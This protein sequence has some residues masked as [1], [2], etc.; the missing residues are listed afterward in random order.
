[1]VFQLSKMENITWHDRSCQQD[2]YFSE[3]LNKSL[4][5]SPDTGWR[6]PQS[7]HMEVSKSENKIQWK[8]QRLNWCAK[9]MT[10]Y[11]TSL[12]MLDVLRVRESLVQEEKQQDKEHSYAWG[13]CL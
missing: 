4:H 9:E 13:A 7:P 1:M 6:K 12:Q 10:S 5:Q 11:K 3:Y 2:Q 8:L